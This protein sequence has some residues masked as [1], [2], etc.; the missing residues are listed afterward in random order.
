MGAVRLDDITIVPLKRIEVTGGDVMH[1]M[2]KADPGYHEFGEA[3][4]SWAKKRHIKAWKLH[5]RMILNLVVPVGEI[6]F[7]FID[8]ADPTKF[9]VEDIG[10]SNY[11]RITVPP[12]IWF[13]FMGI[14]EQDS[15]LLNIANI[16]HEPDETVKEDV[17][18]FSYNWMANHS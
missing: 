3:Y 16:I 14:A 7:V 8:P 12:G 10:I 4:F 18:F 11:A 17:S 5:T 6:R 13:G 2:K 15:L 9:R 1:A